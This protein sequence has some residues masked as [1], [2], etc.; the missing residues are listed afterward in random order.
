[1]ASNG[2]EGKVALF[3]SGSGSLE[4][5]RAWQLIRLSAIFRHTL[6]FTPYQ[7]DF[8]VEVAVK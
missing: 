4:A 5:E 8:F 7:S 1:M 6:A 2:K 3:A